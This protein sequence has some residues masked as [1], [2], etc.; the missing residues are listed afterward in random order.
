[1]GEARQKEEKELVVGAGVVWSA[2]CDGGGKLSGVVAPA[3]SSDRS[4][5]VLSS[6]GG[7]NDPSAELL[8]VGGAKNW[9]RFVAKKDPTEVASDAALVDASVTERER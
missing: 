8:R 5:G 1:V 3:N 6:C 2:E 4:G 9:L 7:G